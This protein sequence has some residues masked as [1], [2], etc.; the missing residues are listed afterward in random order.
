MQRCVDLG[1]GG[2]GGGC[3]SRCYLSLGYPCVNRALPARTSGL[4]AGGSV[5]AGVRPS[6]RN[7]GPQRSPWRRDGLIGLRRWGRSSARRPVAHEI[8]LYRR[9]FQDEV[10]VRARLAIPDRSGA[11]GSASVWTPRRRVLGAG[12][13][14]TSGGAQTGSA[15]PVCGIG[16]RG[17][18]I[19]PEVLDLKGACGSSRDERNAHLMPAQCVVRLDVH[20]VREGPDIVLAVGNWR[21]SRASS[22]RGRWRRR[23]RRTRPRRRPR[24]A[25]TAAQSDSG[26]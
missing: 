5:H 10:T 12:Q 21:V 13:V 16:S 4:G 15:R 14:G 11:R 20:R 2:G 24:C 6:W 18:R 25:S 7:R 9:K 8:D 19:N 3:A 22:S 1:R 23:H 26:R 17:P